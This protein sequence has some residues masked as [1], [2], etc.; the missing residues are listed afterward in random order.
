MTIQVF[1]YHNGYVSHVV[2]NVVV[3]V[4]IYGSLLHQVHMPTTADLLDGPE[5][6][7]EMDSSIRMTKTFSRERTVLSLDSLLQS[8]MFS[9]NPNRGL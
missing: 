8:E 3:V 1:T 2:V 6:E 9:S 4:I 7:A 5:N